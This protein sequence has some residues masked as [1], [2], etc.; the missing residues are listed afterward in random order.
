MFFQKTNEIIN[1]IL[2]GMFLEKLGFETPP[3]RF[4]KDIPLIEDAVKIYLIHGAR[5]HFENGSYHNS[6][7]Q[8]PELQPKIKIRLENS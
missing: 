2:V 6:S 1:F 4:V 5:R 3:L 8:C 7:E